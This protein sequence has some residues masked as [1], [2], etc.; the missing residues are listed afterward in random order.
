MKI[1]GHGTV[2]ALMRRKCG[3]SEAGGTSNKKSIENFMEEVSSYLDMQITAPAMGMKQVVS[4]EQMTRMLDLLY[5]DLE[6]LQEKNI[7]VRVRWNENTLWLL[8]KSNNENEAV[9]FTDL[10]EN[11][12]LGAWREKV[13]YYHSGD[14]EK[15]WNDAHDTSDGKSPKENG[16]MEEIARRIVMFGVRKGN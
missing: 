10:T 4:E 16:R 11:K 7:S 5:A 9:R 6:F 14:L 15:A 12:M 1:C 8:P 3:R 2:L 13:F